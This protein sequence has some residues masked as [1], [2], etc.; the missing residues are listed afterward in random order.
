MRAEGLRFGVYFSGGIDWSFNPEPQLTMADF[1]TSMPGGAFPAHAEAQVRELIERRVCPGSG[2]EAMRT[3][4]M[5]RMI[6]DNIRG[7]IARDPA[8]LACPPESLRRLAGGQRFSD[9]WCAAMGVGN[10]SPTQA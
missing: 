2:A 7:R 1:I 5:R 6:D 10:R 9:L 3:P 8:A 4:A